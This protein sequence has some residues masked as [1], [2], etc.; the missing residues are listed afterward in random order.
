MQWHTQA[1]IISTDLK[2]RID[3]NLPEYSVKK[4]MKWECHMDDFSNGRF[5]MIL[6]RYLLTELVLNIKLY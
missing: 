6:D 5:D 3:F 4:I 2:V 1:G